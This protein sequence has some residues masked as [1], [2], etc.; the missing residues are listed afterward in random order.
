[1]LRRLLA[2]VVK[3]GK[4][5]Y[6]TRNL[7]R[8]WYQ[9]QWQDGKLLREQRAWMFQYSSLIQL[10]STQLDS[11]QISVSEILKA[12]DWSSATTFQRFYNRPP[13]HFQGLQLP[14]DPASAK[15]PCGFPLHALKY[16]ES[17]TVCFPFS[18]YFGSIKG[19]VSQKRS[20]ERGG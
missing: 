16:L 3:R 12:G 1:M 19:I 8:R 10:N 18:R 17:D 5:L 7:I 13:R 14:Y 11:T 20:G 4:C 6:L 9:R 2:F 15:R